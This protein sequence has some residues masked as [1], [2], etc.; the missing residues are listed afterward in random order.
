MPS[1]CPYLLY[2][3]SLWIKLSCFTEAIWKAIYSVQSS[4]SL[5]LPLC[6]LGLVAN[7]LQGKRGPH[8]LWC[9]FTTMPKKSNQG[10]AS[11]HTFC[12]NFSLR[13]VLFVC[14]VL[15]FIC[16][17]KDSWSF[18]SCLIF[19]NKGRTID[20]TACLVSC[21]YMLISGITMYSLLH[22]YLQEYPHTRMVTPIIKEA[23]QSL[24][25]Q[26][27]QSP[28]NSPEWYSTIRW[29]SHVCIPY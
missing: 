9:L 17:W 23:C 27:N 20:N 14:F 24:P 18:V 10:I 25:N 7:R 16:S 1:H 26:R 3:F 29:L 28:W 21:M 12:C 8:K 5:L 19:L 15:F 11:T 6:P 22:L 4:L 13:Q 2:L